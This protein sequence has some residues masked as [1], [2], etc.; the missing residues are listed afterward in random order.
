MGGACDDDVGRSQIVKV[1]LAMVGVDR[2]GRVEAELDLSNGR[3]MFRGC[4]DV[5]EAALLLFVGVV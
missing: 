2:R 3:R 5:D 1:L 4:T